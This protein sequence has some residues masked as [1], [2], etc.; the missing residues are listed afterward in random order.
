MSS[1][2]L[3]CTQCNIVINELLCFVQNKICIM[4]EESLIRLCVGSYST[5]EIT[6]A[7]NLL[8]ESVSTSTRNVSRRKNKE[9]KE[10]EDIISVLKIT[11]PDKTPSFVARVLDRLPPITFDH[12][13]VTTLLKDI[14]IL[15]SEV[16][17]LKESSA[18][19]EQLDVVKQDVHHMKFA[20]VVDLDRNT[21]VNR[22][23]GPFVLN[24]DCESGPV[25]IINISN[26]SNAVLEDDTPGPLNW[27]SPVRPQKPRSACSTSKSGSVTKTTR[28]TADNSVIAPSGGVSAVNLTRQRRSRSVSCSPAMSNKNQ[29]VI[30]SEYG[31][32]K[33]DFRSN[34]HNDDTVNKNKSLA[35]IVC[36]GEWKSQ[37]PNEEW[38]TVQKKRYKNK[39]LQSTQARGIVRGKAVCGPED[40]FKPASSNVTHLF[41][42]NVHKDT[43]ANDIAEYILAKTS[44]KVHLQRIK[45]KQE[46]EYNAYKISVCSERVDM[47]MTGEL[48]PAGVTCRHFRPYKNPQM[49][50]GSHSDKSEK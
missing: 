18:T 38:I 23:R 45:M 2:K 16:K 39:V 36:E 13:D 19:I 22:K 8:F 29:F 4:D 17:Y 50:N 28:S 49:G 42:S 34:D 15:K 20:S 44:D 27:R 33:C 31:V 6:D 11:D 41:L 46:K 40:R 1:D 32:N 24:N 43:S 30:A 7:K 5:A 14:I 21:Y 37:R 12:V 35:D 10:I 26:H 3:K 9:Q 47:F 25:G 48:W